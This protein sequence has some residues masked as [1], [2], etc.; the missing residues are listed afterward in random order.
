MNRFFP[1]FAANDALRTK[2]GSEIVASTLSHAY[3]LEGPRGSGKHTLALQIAAALSCEKKQ[4]FASP[5][6]CGNCPSCKKILGRNSPD[7]ITVGREEKATLGVDAIRKIKTD[8][9]VAP[10][11][12]S[13][14]I[15]VIEDAHLMT[16][17]AQNAFL[18]ALE[19]PP[20][21]VLFLL[22]CEDSKLLL[23]TIRSRAQTLHVEPVDTQT[24]DQYLCKISSE[25]RTLKISNQAEYYEVL[26]IA[27]GRIGAALDLLSPAKRKP[28][29]DL[30][31]KAKQ[32]IRMCSDRANALVTLK[33][34][35]SFGQKREEVLEQLG[36]VQLCL[37]DLLLSKQTDSAPLCFFADREEAHSL[38]YCFTTPA[39]LL[40]CKAVEEAISRLRSNANVKLTLT[41]LAVHSGILQ[42]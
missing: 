17:Q 9:Y 25:A 31:E 29:I 26:S 1:D 28:I 15:Y 21:Y 42:I 8:I 27:D 16:N 4:D 13:V 5:L 36:Y 40:L 41:A 35:A 33:H 2:L 38:A 12:T 11:D 3:I 18:L 23:E 7:I 39:L 14:K 30:R 37:R 22:L 24:M 6:P 20:E 19:E 10:N 32:F 34:I